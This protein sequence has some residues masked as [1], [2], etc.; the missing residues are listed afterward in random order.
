MPQL[1]KSRYKE[2]MGIFNWKLFCV[3]KE[4]KVIFP[5]FLYSLYKATLFYLF[6]VP[7]NPTDKRVSKFKYDI[8]LVKYDIYLVT[9]TY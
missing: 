1:D 4:R 9:M 2:Y 7:A 6:S 5:F 8:Y 3:K